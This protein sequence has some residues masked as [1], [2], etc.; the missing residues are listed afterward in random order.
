VGRGN[1]QEWVSGSKDR[2]VR[3]GVTAA[4]QVSR[5]SCSMS[6]WIVELRSGAQRSSI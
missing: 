6:A 1:I 2:A 5:E 3:D 4:I